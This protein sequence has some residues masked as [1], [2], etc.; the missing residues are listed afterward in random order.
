M[1]IT[2]RVHEIVRDEHALTLADVVLV[3]PGTLERTSSGKVRRRHTR[4]L[5]R[6][7]KLVLA[8]SSSRLRQ[9]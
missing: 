3:K 6:Q 1:T 4:E 9:V 7:G 5:Y 2:A 8:G